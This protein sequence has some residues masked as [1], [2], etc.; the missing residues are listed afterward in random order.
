MICSPFS[1]WTLRIANSRSCLRSV[2]APSTPSSSAMLTSSAGVF[3]LRSLRCMGMS[4]GRAGSSIGAWGTA[5]PRAGPRADAERP[6]A[7]ARRARSR[8]S[9]GADLPPV[10]KSAGS[11]RLDDHQDDDQRDGDAGHLVHQPQL[12]AASAVGSPRASFLR[13][14]DHPA[15]IAGQR[16]HAAAAWRA[17]SRARQHRRQPDVDASASPSTQTDDHRRRQDDRAQLPSRSIHSRVLGR[18]RRAS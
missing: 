6:L 17:A 10:A 9:Q 13:I 3:F 15:V 1:A 18:S 11:E 14:A 4:G 5:K 7:R 16:E 8:S 12:L 2:E